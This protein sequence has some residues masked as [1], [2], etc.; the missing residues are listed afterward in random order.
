[1]A[2]QMQRA[3]GQLGRAL[4]QV[5]QRTAE[6]VGAGDQYSQALQEYARSKAWQQFG[7]NA[8]QF[9]KK[10]APTAIGIGAGGRLAIDSLLP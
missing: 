3:V 1:M 9:I 4:G 7:A 2:P 5:L 8:W 6:S 10:A